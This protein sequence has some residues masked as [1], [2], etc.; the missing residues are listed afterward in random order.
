MKTY[1][2]KPTK[3]GFGNQYV[4]VDPY[5]N[6]RFYEL[7][8]MPEY[9]YEQELQLSKTFKVESLSKVIDYLSE[10][11]IHVTFTDR[12]ILD[13]K[14]W[15]AKD[16]Q[17][18]KY[19]PI[20]ELEGNNICINPR[21]IDFLSILFSIGHIY[22]HLVQRMDA[23]RYAPI[24]DFLDYPKPLDLELILKEYKEKYGG[25]YKEDF[26][27]F[28]IEAFR[29]AKFT[30]MEA[31][32]EFDEMMDHA[33]NVYILSDFQ[34]LWRWVSNSPLKSGE[35]FMEVFQEMFLSTRGQ[36]KPLEP[37]EIKVRVIPAREGVLEIVRDEHGW[38][39]KI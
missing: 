24:T 1:E 6:P 10:R 12:L 29:Y 36:H 2:F 37:K 13:D 16:G 26:L 31:G 8:F 21:N 28:E 20:A 17:N 38:T 19:L 27:E 3:Q 22:G 25:N 34:E 18:Y 15:E 33:M 11:D 23:E 35:S 4:E 32:I 39:E 5:N 14:K 9:P 7:R 30:F